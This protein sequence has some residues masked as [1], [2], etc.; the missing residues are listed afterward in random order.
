MDFAEL[1][2]QRFIEAAPPEKAWLKLNKNKLTGKVVHHST[3]RNGRKDSKLR[4]PQS[5]LLRDELLFDL[6]N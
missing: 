6:A 1:T 5:G 3:L 2:I 4:S